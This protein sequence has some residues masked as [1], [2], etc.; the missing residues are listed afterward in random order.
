[1]SGRRHWWA[2]TMPHVQNNPGRPLLCP[3]IWD[4]A[5]PHCTAY[6]VKVYWWQVNPASEIRM[7]FGSLNG[8]FHR[9]LGYVK[10][11]RVSCAWSSC[12]FMSLFYSQ[13]CASAIDEAEAVCT[14]E[15]LAAFTCIDFVLVLLTGES[16]LE[17]LVQKEKHATRVQTAVVAK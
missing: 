16:L 3:V 9:H 13:S 10:F 8:K 1:M 7:L 4:L 17:S 6:C 15:N 2:V 5:E 14:M 12:V 11:W